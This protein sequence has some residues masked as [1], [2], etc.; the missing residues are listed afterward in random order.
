[1]FL[2]NENPHAFTKGVQAILNGEL[3]FSRDILV[4]CLLEIGDAVKPLEESKPRLTPREKE[5]LTMLASGSTNDKIAEEFYISPQTVKTH[6]CNIYKKINAPNR[7]QAAL[8]AT[9]NL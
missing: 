4:K 6:I 2:E 1:M 3:W 9:R 5:I 8:W 7:I